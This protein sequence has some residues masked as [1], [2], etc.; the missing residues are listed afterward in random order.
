M[1]E[2]LK[3]TIYNPNTGDTTETEI[4]PG[5]YLLLCAEPAHRTALNAW[6]T[7]THQITVKG[8][9]DPMAGVYNRTG[10]NRG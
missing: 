1:P 5:S 6:A 8:V 3:V 9:T 2:P 10:G 7:G 4:G